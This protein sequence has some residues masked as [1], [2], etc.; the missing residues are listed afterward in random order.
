MRHA[1]SIPLRSHARTHARLTALPPGPVRGC[2]APQRW[3]Q[4]LTLEFTHSPHVYFNFQEDTGMILFNKKHWL[5]K[6]I[7]GIVGLV[8]LI[9]VINVTAG[10]GAKQPTGATAAPATGSAAKGCHDLAAWEKN[11]YSGN[12]VQIDTNLQNKIA[13]DARGT[14]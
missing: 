9:V 3:R 14:K 5:R 8:V 7:L 11:T 10:G 2:Q 6:I 13:A 12:S 1:A 4:G